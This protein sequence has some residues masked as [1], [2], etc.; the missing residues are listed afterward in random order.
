MRVSLLTGGDDPNYAI[1][2]AESLARQGIDVEFIGND[3]MQTAHGLG[4]V[5]IK[6]LNL[7][8]DQDPRAPLASKIG[9]IVRYYAKLIA[10][11]MTTE[12]RVFHILWLNKVDWLDR[13]L[14]NAFYRLNG[15]RVVFTAHNV[16]AKKRDGADT[17]ANRLTLKAMY[18][19][20]DHIFVHTESAKEELVFEYGVLPDKVTVIPF[21]LNTFV[22]DTPLSKREARAHLGLDADEQ[23]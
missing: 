11:T 13:T 22:P 12:S 10:Y 16:N 17:R 5:N 8:G 19:R 23:V 1:P 15:K 6:Y 4:H 2:L 7:R 20:L 3:A 9:R 18:S 14:V 21:G